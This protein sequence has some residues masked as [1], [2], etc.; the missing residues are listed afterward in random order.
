M[1]L[2]ERSNIWNQKNEEM[3]NIYEMTTLDNESTV[4]TAFSYRN[5]IAQDLIIEDEDQKIF[6]VS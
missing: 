2:V 3:N 1:L 5:K 4:N 6:K